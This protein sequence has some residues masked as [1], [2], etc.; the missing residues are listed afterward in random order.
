MVQ[1]V[2]AHGV[3]C[4][5]QMLRCRFRIC[6]PADVHQAAFHLQLNELEQL[7]L[8]LLSL[9]AMTEL[10]QMVGVVSEIAVEAL[11]ILH[12]QLKQNQTQLIHELKLCEL[13]ELKVLVVDDHTLLGMA[14][15]LNW[16]SIQNVLNNCSFV[17]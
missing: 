13:D 16:S 7:H 11:K 2:A 3:G 12:L 15:V 10:L 5:L 6:V 17:N 9:H 4:Q 1:L 14:V 8:F